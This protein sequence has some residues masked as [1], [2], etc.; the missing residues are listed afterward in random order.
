MKKQPVEIVWEATA[1]A[2]IAAITFGLSLHWG[3]ELLG[4]LVD[5]LVRR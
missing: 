2:L 1:I 5:W 4:M 3:N